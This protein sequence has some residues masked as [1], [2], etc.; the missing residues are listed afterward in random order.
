M[1]L[2]TLVNRTIESNAQRLFSKLAL[3]EKRM[4]DPKDIY[5]EIVS[6]GPSI[7]EMLKRHHKELGITQAAL[8]DSAEH[9]AKSKDESPL[10][11]DKKPEQDD[12]QDFP[13]VHK[14]QP[15]QYNRQKKAQDANQKTET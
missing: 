12:S 9:P 15:R 4:A 2:L 7:G 8:S 10:G 5:E 3:L 13:V 14:I 6:W 11:D 1:D